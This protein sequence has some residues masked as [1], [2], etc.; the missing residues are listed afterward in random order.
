[1]KDRKKA[2]IAIQ[3]ISDKHFSH[4][5]ATEDCSLS[6]VCPLGDFEYVELE[7]KLEHEFGMV[8]DLSEMSTVGDVLDFIM[9]G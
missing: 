5:I 2:F 7:L 4:T 1:M 9:K 3:R 8:F 6:A